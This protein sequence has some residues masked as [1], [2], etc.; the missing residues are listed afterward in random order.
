MT[1]EQ[2]WY[3]DPLMVRAY[4]KADRIRQQ[5]M[6]D[7]AWLYGAY[8]LKAMQSALSI[9]DLF[10]PKGMHK[11]IEYPEKPIELETESERRVD[12]EKRE[13]QEAL[14][15]QAYMMNMVAFGQNWGKKK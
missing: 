13:E 12:D 1:Y 4:Y 5:R 10:R 14:Y 3:G 7:E 8:V 15:A 11:A 6:N 9:S 2:Y